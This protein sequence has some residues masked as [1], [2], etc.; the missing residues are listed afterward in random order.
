VFDHN[1]TIGDDFEV[2]WPYSRL[3]AILPYYDGDVRTIKVLYK[4]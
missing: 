3:D 1:G 2:I 4:Y